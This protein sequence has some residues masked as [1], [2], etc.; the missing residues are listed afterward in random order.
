MPTQTFFNLPAGKRQK[1]LEA[2]YA[3]FSRVPYDEVS[4]NQ[5]IRAAGIP[6]G[7]FYQY[8][9]GKQDVLD[10]LLAGYRQLMEQQALESLQTSGGDLFTL[11][12][13]LLDFTY[14]YVSREEHN[15][16]FRHVLADVRHNTHLFPVREKRDLQGEL[17][18]RLLARLDTAQ[19][20]IRSAADLEDMLGVLV[21]MTG[22]AFAHAFFDTSSY[23]VVRE[24][25]AARLRIL[26][27]GFCLDKN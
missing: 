27:R 15:T 16:F 19:L 14:A 2:I 18:R 4:I 13:D 12:L 23:E 7:S 5:I 22:E 11:F 1:L 3:E 21:P 26:G 25:Y 6:R 10:Y 24:R 8:F 20:D 17:A 9:A